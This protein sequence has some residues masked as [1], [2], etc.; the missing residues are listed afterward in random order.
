[1]GQ[2]TDAGTNVTVTGWGN[3]EYGNTN[4]P[5]ELNK[6]SIPTVTDQTCRR[7]YGPFDMFDSFI[8][9]GIP[10]GSYTASLWKLSLFC[11]KTK[12]YLTTGGKDSCD[13]DSGGPLFTSD[14]QELIGIVSWGKDCGKFDLLLHSTDR[15]TSNSI[16]FLLLLLI[17][18]FAALPGYYGVYTEVSYFTDWIFA[19]IAAN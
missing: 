17:C 16:S 10:E 14:P 6:V 19:T 12:K 15:L 4:R 18:T 7:A 1:M 8:C 3:L 2:Q 9:A 11:S 5:D 13:G